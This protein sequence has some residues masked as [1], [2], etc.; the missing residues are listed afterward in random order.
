[1]KWWGYFHRNGSVQIKRLLN[2]YDLEE[3]EDS[4]F[5]SFVIG[6]VE[7]NSREEAENKLKQILKERFNKIGE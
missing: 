2:E 3:A 5:V 7:A 4:P 1:M 6:T